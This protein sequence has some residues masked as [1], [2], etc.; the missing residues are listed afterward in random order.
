[1]RD[2]DILEELYKDIPK[3]IDILISHDAPYGCSDIC[4]EDIY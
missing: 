1:M 2:D 3:N 4:F